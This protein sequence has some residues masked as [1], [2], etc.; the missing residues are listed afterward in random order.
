V[1]EQEGNPMDKFK[2]LSSAAAVLYASV[3]RTVVPL[4]VGVV[5]TWA[6]AA[7]IEVDDKLEAALGAVLTALFGTLWYV[8]ARVLEVYVSPRFGWLLGLAKSP[9]TYSTD[10]PGRHEA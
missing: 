7:G 3:V 9:D 10:Q 8:A 2:D 4:L 1:T 5:L 6:A